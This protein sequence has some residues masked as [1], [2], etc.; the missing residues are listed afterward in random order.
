MKKILLLMLVP[1]MALTS[2]SAQTLTDF[3][4]NHT[5]KVTYDDYFNP[6]L[7]LTLTNVSLITITSIEI[8]VDY[9]DNP[10]DWRNEPERICRQVTISPYQTTTVSIRVPKEKHSSKPKKFWIS[11]VRFSDGTICDKW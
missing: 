9:S 10:Y 4:K 7:H 6:T 11:N 8:C 5:Y 1:L 2:V 3:N